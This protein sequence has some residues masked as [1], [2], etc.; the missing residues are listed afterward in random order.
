MERLKIMPGEPFDR[1]I[2][3][4]IASSKEKEVQA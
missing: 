4:F 1:V 2:R 3:R